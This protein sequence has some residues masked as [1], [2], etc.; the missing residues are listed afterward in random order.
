MTRKML[1]AALAALVL[2]GLAACSSQPLQGLTENEIYY[3][4]K[5]AYGIPLYTNPF[6]GRVA[7]EERCNP[8]G[9]STTFWDDYGRFFRIDYLRIDEHPMAQAPRF[10]SDQTLLNAVMNNYLREVLPQA[11]AIEDAN[12]SV[13]E[14]LRDRDPRALFVIMDINVD[15]LRTAQ[16]QDKRTLL[17]LP[18][19]TLDAQSEPI[20][21]TYYYGFLLFKR[22]EFVYVLQHYQ[23]AYMKDKMLQSL[24]RLAENMI[25]PGKSRSPT[26]IEQAKMRWAKTRESMRLGD[27]PVE[28]EETT[29]NPVRPCD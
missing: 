17:G 1:R 9:G 15:T 25:I 2:A 18:L 14:F 19:P 13:R 24:S 8:A 11:E 6:R 4:P 3:S 16:Q 10:A 27:R 20:R 29:V 21:G 28:S 23:P 7:L 5:Q 22:G 26:E 12:T